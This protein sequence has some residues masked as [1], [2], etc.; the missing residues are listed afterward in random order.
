MSVAWWRTRREIETK[1]RKGKSAS[2]ISHEFVR[3][4]RNRKGLNSFFPFITA[5]RNFWETKMAIALQS[6]ETIRISSFFVEIDLYFQ[7][8]FSWIGRLCR[9]SNKRFVTSNICNERYQSIS[10][11]GWSVV[12][13]FYAFGKRGRGER[14]RSCTYC[15]G[16]RT[17]WCVWCDTKVF[18]CSLFIK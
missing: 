3:P 18:F 7:S 10:S 17:S 15:P 14:W 8:Q 12:F 11:S 2:H 5:D 9:F 1:E 16:L 13:A 4:K 6:E